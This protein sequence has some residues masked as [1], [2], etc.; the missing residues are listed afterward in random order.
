[1]PEPSNYKL[2]GA[3]IDA[4]VADDWYSAVC[5]W[6]IVDMEE[7]ERC[8][9][10]CVCGHEHLRYLFT[11]KNRMNGNELYPIGN[12][13]IKKFECDDLDNELRVRMQVIKLAQTA[14][15]LGTGRQVELKDGSFTRDLINYL[16]DEKIFPDNKYNNWDG[17]NDG[18]FLLDMFNKPSD[19]TEKQRKK[20][21]VTI[22]NA[23][24]PWLR[25]MWKDTHNGQSPRF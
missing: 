10:S 22:K 12:V 8:E 20:V 5:E 25:E 13:C 6:D 23:V 16:R 7:D 1:M 24:Y 9:Q 14:N 2:I 17:D 18:R 21:Y 4:S 19:L 15:A 3:V 11:L